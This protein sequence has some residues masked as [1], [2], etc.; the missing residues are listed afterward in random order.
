MH[1]TTKCI[2]SQLN[3]ASRCFI[4]EQCFGSACR[5]RAHLLEDPGQELQ[6]RVLQNF[7][8]RAGV[9]ELEDGWGASLAL[10]LTSQLKRSCK[11]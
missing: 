4:A 7:G 6:P 11:Y 5:G 1:Q 10:T 3:I 8:V 2:Y 9:E